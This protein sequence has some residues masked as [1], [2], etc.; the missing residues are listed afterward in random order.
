MHLTQCILH[1]IQPGLVDVIDWADLASPNAF[2]VKGL[3]SE[4]EVEYNKIGV[5][6]KKR[7][8]RVI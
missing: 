7:K 3:I 2:L 8:R 5:S 4:D 6:Q 1:S